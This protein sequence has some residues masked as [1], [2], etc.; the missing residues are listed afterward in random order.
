MGYVYMG[1][2]IGV[3]LFFIICLPLLPIL[4]VVGI[5]IVM[6]MELV[7]S[8]EDMLEDYGK[9]LRRLYEKA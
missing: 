6:I 3:V 4:V 2:L 8:V 5:V 7:A 9:K 1:A